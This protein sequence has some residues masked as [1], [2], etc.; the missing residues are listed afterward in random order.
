MECSWIIIILVL[1]VIIFMSSGS[2]T[3]DFQCSKP[4]L[5][6]CGLGKWWTNN[7]D[8]KSYKEPNSCAQKDKGR[9]GDYKNNG[10]RCECKSTLGLKSLAW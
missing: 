7:T 2:C 10:T 3:E 6:C 1:L 5:K 4:G 8:M 9:L